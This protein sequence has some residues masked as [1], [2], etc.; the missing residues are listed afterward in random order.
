LAGSPFTGL[1][2]PVFEHSR[3]H[4]FPDQADDARVTDPMFNETDHPFLVN[5]V[6]KRT[7]VGV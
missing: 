1:E 2:L 3:L 5:H 7:N 6:E 4:P